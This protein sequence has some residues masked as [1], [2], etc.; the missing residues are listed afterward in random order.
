M[1]I[2]IRRILENTFLGTGY[3]VVLEY[4]FND[5]TIITIK[6][7]GAEEGD[8][9]S[10]LASKESQVLSNKI[11]QDLDTIV[12]ND[13]DTPT[14]DTTQAQVWK[15][16][17][18]RGHNSKDPIYAYEHLSKVAQ[19]VLDLGL[20]NQQLADQFGEPV[21]V[22]TAV[23]NKWEYLN[24]NKDAILSYKTIKEGM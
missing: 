11:S 7:R 4:V 23:L 10:F 24:T 1:P 2:I 5:G 3:R 18:T 8:A 21:E 13:S 15:E 9:E 22:I 20:T 12:L 6:C 16:W 17:L 19:T 14:E